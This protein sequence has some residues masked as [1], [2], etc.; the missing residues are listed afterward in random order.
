[1]ADALDKQIEQLRNMVAALEA[2]RSLLGPAAVDTVVAGLRQQLTA[3]SP[4]AANSC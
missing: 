2:Q 3:L 1:M 4:E